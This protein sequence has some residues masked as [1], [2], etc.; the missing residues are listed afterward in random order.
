MTVSGYKKSVKRIRK[1]LLTAGATI[2]LMASLCACGA[3]K[4]DVTKI[5][6]NKDGTILNEI[7]DNFE[8]DYYQLSELE[9]MAAKEISYYNSEYITPK[10]NLDESELDDNGRVT[11]KINYNSYIDYAHF[12]QITFFYGT[13]EEA[14]SRGFSIPEDLVNSDGE[15]MSFD[16][17]KELDERHVI[18]SGDKNRIEAPYNIS[19][20]TRNVTLTD[21]READLSEVSE[22]LAWLLLSK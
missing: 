10:I 14:Y 21:K 7:Y 12:N 17:L 18:I 6:V 1:A 19:Y 5:I 9:D 15:K 11:L 4:E 8:E 2:M 22:D 13:V 3:A 16:N 20:M